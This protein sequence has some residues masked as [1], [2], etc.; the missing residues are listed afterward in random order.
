MVHPRQRAHLGPP[1]RR[2]VLLCGLVDRL[3]IGGTLHIA[4]D[5]DDYAAQ[6]LAVC[7]AEPRLCGGVVL[8]PDWRPVTRFEQRGLNAG[9]IATDMIYERIV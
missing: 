5:I 3:R 6:A 8:R 2:A 9:R 7:A 1:Q 4:T